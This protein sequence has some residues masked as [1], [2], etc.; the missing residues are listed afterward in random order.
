VH[1]I[2]L[3]CT[4]TL[5]SRDTPHTMC[6]EMMRHLYEMHGITDP[7]DLTCLCSCH[8]P[9]KSEMRKARGW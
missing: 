9:L 3:E 4:A 1:I 5:S 2:S 8:E 6:D 7:E